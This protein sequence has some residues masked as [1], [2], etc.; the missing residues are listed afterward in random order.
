MLKTVKGKF[1]FYSTIFIITTVS[2]PMIFL[3]LQM[4]N[5]FEERSKILLNTV[6]DMTSYR[7]DLAMDSEKK[8]IRAIVNELSEDRNIDNI[9]ILSPAGLVNYAN[10]STDENK[11]INDLSDQKLFKPDER[12]KIIYSADEKKYLAI[13]PIFNTAKCQTCH[14]KDVI[15]GYLN[16]ETDATDAEVNFF[17]GIVHIIMFGLVVIVVLLVGSNKLYDI[18]IN[19]PLNNFLNAIDKVENGDFEVRIKHFNEDEFGVLTN[20]FNK[21]MDYLVESRAEI[22]ELN[23]QKLQRADRLVTLGELTAGIAHEIN[24]NTAIIMTRVD[25][26]R[27]ASTQDKSLVKYREDLDVIIHQL[28]LLSKITGETLKYSKKPG[29]SFSQINLTEVIDNS[30][31]MLRPVAKK[32]DIAIIKKY[33]SEE[34]IWIEGNFVQLEQ[35][36]NNLIGNALDALNPGGK[37]TIDIVSDIDSY[38]VSVSDNGCGIKPEILK[39]IFLPFFTTKSEEEG[40]GLGL[41]IVKNICNSHDIKLRCESEIENGTTFYLNIKKYG[42]R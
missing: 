19:K 7:L 38:E 17:T 5:N 40:T 14:G 9:R 36:F 12:R 30:L 21:M 29:G 28:E 10:D 11:M 24:N 39:N 18:F 31:D 2:L 1:I 35:V 16:V 34:N 41:Y 3:L 33:T 15:L 32:R 27:L 26:L 42:T 8:D 20:H 37:V 25:Y 13:E 22:E 4:K 23:F 6:F